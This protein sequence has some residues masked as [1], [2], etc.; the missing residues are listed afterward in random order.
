[1]SPGSS[2]CANGFGSSMSYRSSPYVHSTNNCINNPVFSLQCPDTVGHLAC[3]NVAVNYKQ[4]QIISTTTQICHTS[5]SYWQNLT[6]ASDTGLW[7]TIFRT[8]WEKLWLTN[9]ASSERFFGEFKLLPSSCGGSVAVSLTVR[10][11]VSQ[12]QKCAALISN[13]STSLK[14][15]IKQCYN[16]QLT[17][18][19]PAQQLVFK[20]NTPQ[21]ASWV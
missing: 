17:A 11:S 18:V 15:A 1:M 6:T 19:A 14:S 8:C 16:T 9:V 20:K 12:S 2:S 5:H 7:L 13:S 10:R 3:E 21:S 4:D